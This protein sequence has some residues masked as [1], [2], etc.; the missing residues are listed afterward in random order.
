MGEVAVLFK[1]YAEEGR[2]EEVGKGIVKQ[3][4]PKA[5]QLEDV[6]FGIKIIKVLFVHDDKEGSSVVEEKLKSFPGVREVEV[7]EESLI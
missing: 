7:E 1:I 2:E 3:L 4:K 6:A 5:L